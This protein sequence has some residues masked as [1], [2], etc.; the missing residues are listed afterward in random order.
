MILDR[1]KEFFKTSYEL[2]C[3]CE[4]Y[5]YYPHLSEKTEELEK[6][7]EFV[8]EQSYRNCTKYEERFVRRLRCRECGAEYTWKD[9]TITRVDFGDEDEDAGMKLDMDMTGTP[10]GN[11]VR[12]DEKPIIDRRE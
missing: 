3:G 6:R 7:N 10:M 9:S 1:L 5:D 2:P 11:I 4:S 8:S 12:Y